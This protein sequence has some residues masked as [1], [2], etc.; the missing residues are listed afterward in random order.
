MDKTISKNFRTLTRQGE[1]VRC[2]LYGQLVGEL[3]ALSLT[4]EVTFD[5]AEAVSAFIDDNLV[6]VHTFSLSLS[7]EELKALLS[8]A[9]DTVESVKDV[10][11]P[12]VAEEETP[13]V[14]KKRRR[15]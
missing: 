1:L 8:D 2:Y 14:F 13:V 5:L 9:A 4:E 12:V 11:A 15:S 6:A 10:E 7:S 3:S